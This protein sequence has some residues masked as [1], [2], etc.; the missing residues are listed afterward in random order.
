MVFFCDVTI[1]SKNW[2]PDG[3]N[4]GQHTQVPKFF[5][6]KMRFFKPRHKHFDFFTHDFCLLPFAP[7][8]FVGNEAIFKQC[9]HW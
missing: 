4:F 2:K 7:K 5:A 6:P 9:K 1:F 3:Q 8:I